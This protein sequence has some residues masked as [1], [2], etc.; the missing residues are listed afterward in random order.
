MF[1]WKRKPEKK[2]QMQERQEQRLIASKNKIDC[3]DKAMAILNAI[4]INRRIEDIGPGMNGE[5]RIAHGN[6]VM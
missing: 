1:G 3:A 4:R 2:T 5:R 6:G